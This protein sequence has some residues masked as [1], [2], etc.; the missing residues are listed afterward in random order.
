MKHPQQKTSRSQWVNKLKEGSEKKFVK[1]VIRKEWLITGTMRR[2]WDWLAWVVL[3]HVLVLS[4]TRGNPSLEEKWSIFPYFSSSDGF[5]RVTDDAHRTGITSVTHGKLIYF[6]HAL[7]SS[8]WRGRWRCTALTARCCE[9]N[10]SRERVQ[11]V[12]WWSREAR[13]CLRS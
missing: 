10:L 2:R 1:T 9:G 12:V 6:A 13:E 4:V 3:L 7:G 8:A 5:P 11:Q